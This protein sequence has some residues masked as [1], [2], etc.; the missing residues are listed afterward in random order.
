MKTEE[1]QKFYNIDIEGVKTNV[2]REGLYVI[3]QVWAGGNYME[4][5]AGQEKDIPLY[6]ITI[7]KRW[8]KK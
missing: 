5:T 1:L 4:Y 8:S 6:I 2:R 3:V 7:L